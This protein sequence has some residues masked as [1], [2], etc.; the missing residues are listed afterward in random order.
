MGVHTDITGQVDA[1]RTLQ[2]LN[3]LLEQ[4]VQE[5][6]RALAESERRF[7]SIFDSQ[8]QLIGLLEPD[9]TLI[10]ANR[11]ALD[12][13]GVTLEDVVGR[14]FWTAPWWRYSDE[15]LQELRD[16]LR[17]AASGETVRYDVDILD[18][19]GQA[20]TIDFS[21]KPVFGDQG[22]VILLIPEGRIISEERRLAAVLQAVVSSAPLILFALDR[23]GRYLLSDGAAL[24][25]LGRQPNELIGQSAHE[26][27]RQQPQ[28]LEP[29]KR[30]LV[31][32]KVHEIG[33]MRGS[34]SRAGTSR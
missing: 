6:T 7:R 15:V 26:V 20:A 16:A 5:R 25:T 32:E 27:Y 34:R 18:M 4:R 31:G 33:T 11:T 21:L 2:D 22:Q 13:A 19:N 1:Q 9:G 23:Q 3:A 14:P 28:V 17:R 8:F 12:F 10:E 29:M 24:A 30:A